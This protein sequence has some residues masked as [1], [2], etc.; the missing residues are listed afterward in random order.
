MIQFKL[1]YFI[2]PKDSLKPL[3]YFYRIARPGEQYQFEN[4]KQVHHLIK[5]K[6][7]EGWTYVFKEETDDGFVLFF[8]RDKE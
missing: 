4:E 6:L 5:E 2:I 7:K 1:K 8:K 3:D